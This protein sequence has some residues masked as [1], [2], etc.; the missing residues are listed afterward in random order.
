MNFNQKELLKINNAVDEC[1]NSLVR[2]QS[3]KDF[4][5]DVQ[6]RMKDELG[7]DKDT[8]KYFKLAVNERYKEDVAEKMKVFEDS[9]SFNDQ[10]LEAESNHK[11]MQGNNQLDDTE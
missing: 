6:E 2:E 3:E 5:K 11:T 1:V 8:L 4:R 7:M 10:L 9:L